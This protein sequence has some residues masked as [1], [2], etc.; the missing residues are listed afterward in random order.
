[1]ELGYG[2]TSSV[3]ECRNSLVSLGAR[4]MN[5]RCVAKV[6]AYMAR[7]CSGLEDAGGLHSFWDNSQQAQDAKDKQVTDPPNTWNVE[8]FILTLKELVHTYFLNKF[9][10]L[11]INFNFKYLKHLICT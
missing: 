9:I 11:H 6:L 4:D 5:A 10:L 7:T 8:V 1:M 3:E 2:F